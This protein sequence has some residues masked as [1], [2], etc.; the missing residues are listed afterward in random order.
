M[1][2]RFVTSKN[3]PDSMNWMKE[4]PKH[5]REGSIKD[6]ITSR[7]AAFTN[8]RKGNISKFNIGFRKKKETQSIVIPKDFIKADKDPGFMC[9]P[10]FLKSKLLTRT[11][12]PVIRHDCRLVF[13]ND[14]F[15]LYVPIDVQASERK[16]MDKN[17]CS[18]DPGVRTFATT[19]SPGG[20]S[21]FG[22]GLAS[23]MFS[24][25]VSMDKLRSKIDTEKDKRKRKR[26]IHVFKRL[27]SRFQN[28]LRDFHYKVASVLCSDYDNIIIPG[29]GSKDMVSK[30]NRRLKT[31]TV[32]EMSCLGHAKFR[33]RLSDV[34]RRKGKHIHILSE[35]Y[36]SKTCCACG[37]LNEKL[38]GKKSFKCENCYF[39]APRDIHGAFNIFLK[40]MNENSITLVVERHQR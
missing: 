38:G 12:V 8:K 26:K 22:T 18:I 14:S 20:V 33:Q 1:R 35:E 39:E 10:R 27:S 34:A 24:R 17:F 23:D 32:R 11:K 36:T 30:K 5:V 15:Y 19:W 21:E 4:T 29:F 3:I 16:P 7:K 40:F 2:N 31:K 37:T 6:F 25:L 13:N 28:K 9:Y